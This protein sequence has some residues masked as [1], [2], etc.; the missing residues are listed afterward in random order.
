MFQAGMTGPV[1]NGPAK[2]LL[3]LHHPALRRPS[4]DVEVYA[5]KLA[6]L[7]AGARVLVM[8]SAQ[9]G[10][11]EMSTEDWSN[12]HTNADASISWGTELGSTRGT[13]ISRNKS[14]GAWSIKLDDGDFTEGRLLEQVPTSRLLAGMRTRVLINPS[15]SVDAMESHVRIMW[16]EP[17]AE[18]AV[19]M[20]MNGAPIPPADNVIWI[21]QIAEGRLALRINGGPLIPCKPSRGMA[22]ETAPW[23]KWW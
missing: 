2:F 19:A 17:V 13:V 11:G 9:H 8:G 5:A 6:R 22:Q 4:S 1:D 15:T 18:G 10:A 3:E 16:P 14:S 7:E 23:W 12:I 20:E 21:R